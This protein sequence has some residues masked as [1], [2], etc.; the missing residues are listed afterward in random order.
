MPYN[1]RILEGRV[2]DPVLPWWKEVYKWARS[3]PV[4]LG[5]NMRATY[6]PL[7]MKIR[8]ATA[9]PVRIS[10][11]AGLS[12]RQVRVGTGFVEN[13]VP[14]IEVSSG[15]YV[16]LDG[17]TAEGD[18]DPAGR[19]K[20]NLDDAEPGPDDR[21]AVVVAVQLGD[22]GEFPTAEELAESPDRLQVEHRS[23][24]SANARRLAGQEGR[25]FHV[26]AIVYWRNDAPV[27]IG[28][29][30]M[31]DYVLLESETETADGE[32]EKRY[33]FSAA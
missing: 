17:K 4:V 26:L 6:G 30:A 7:G 13:E 9:R 31:H 15:R 16:R 1:R 18:D 28:Q 23:D 8:I 12:G 10:W 25:P 19:P 29:V 27:R 32:T 14:T 3:L 21:S 20:L 22:G 24:F 2:G 11:R 5:P 33:F